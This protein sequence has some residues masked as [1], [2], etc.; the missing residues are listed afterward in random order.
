MRSALVSLNSINHR[1]VEALY[2]DLTQA[3]THPFD[4]IALLRKPSVFR[5][6]ARAAH[7]RM[8]DIFL[9]HGFVL[10]QQVAS[11]YYNNIDDHDALS[12]D[13]GEHM[14]AKLHS[15]LIDQMLRV[16][17]DRGSMVFKYPNFPL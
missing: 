12:L 10:G 16:T 4:W 15:A 11:D 13:A 14:T 2:M 9:Q 1:R 8:Q 7:K 5:R 17:G 3:F 6:K